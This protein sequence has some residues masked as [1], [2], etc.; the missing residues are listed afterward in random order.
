MTLMPDQALCLDPASSA[1]VT[2]VG[3][4]P[5]HPDLITIA[6]LKVLL[7]AD[8]VVTDRLVSHELLARLAPDVELIDVAKF[9]RS[10]FT[11]REDIN[12]VLLDRAR[13]ER[14]SSASRE[15]TAD[16]GRTDQHV[17]ED[18]FGDVGHGAELGKVVADDRDSHRGL[19][20]VT[21]NSP[22]WRA[23]MTSPTLPP[24]VVQILI[25]DTWDTDRSR[26]WRTTR[27]SV[28][29]RPASS[30]VIASVISPRPWCTVL[31]WCARRAPMGIGRA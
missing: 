26:G 3:A 17:V 4:G 14:G 25:P 12:A 28:A 10:R 11:A 6:G 19:A 9:P 2:L 13:A 8:V 5:G 23:S 30:P 1:G 27:V 15:A 31:I 20:R 22:A 24:R 16:T 7:G 18:S 21:M 29:G